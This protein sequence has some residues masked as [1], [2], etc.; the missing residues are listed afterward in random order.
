MEPTP[1]GPDAA[2]NHVRILHQG[3]PELIAYRDGISEWKILEVTDRRGFDI[4]VTD[5]YVFMDVCVSGQSFVAFEVRS[6]VSE[7]PEIGGVRTWGVGVCGEFTIG[8]L[9]V[10]GRMAQPGTVAIGSQT[11]LG[12]SRPWTFNLDVTPGTH[13][14]VASDSSDPTVNGPRVLIRRSRDFTQSLTEPDID[15]SMQGVPMDTITLDAQGLE[16]GDSLSTIVS[17]DTANNTYADVSRTSTASGYVVPAGILIDGDNQ[18]VEFSSGTPGVSSRGAF[19]SYNGRPISFTLLPKL[20]GLVSFSLSSPY[21]VMASWAS[22]PPYSY[23]ALRN[24]GS[25]GRKRVLASAGWV[26]RHSV[27]SFQFDTSV[28]GYKPEWSFVSTNRSFTLTEDSNEITY[29]SSIYD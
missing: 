6:T 4:C 17:L 21:D 9:Q 24:S 12:T 3:S 11:V 1:C 20:T 13:D 22:L 5:D 25:L 29:F 16:A 26:S 8:S 10:T 28:P 27:M 14:L 18:T 2:P 7:T 15:L 19:L 23:V